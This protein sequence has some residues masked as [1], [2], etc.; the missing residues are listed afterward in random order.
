M[1]LEIQDVS[2]LL[3]LS[4]EEV[5][6][7]ALGGKLPAYRLGENRPYR[8]SKMEIEE[9]MMKN[10]VA[11]KF[12]DEKSG[13]EKTPGFSHFSLFRALTK[14]AV[15]T[16]LKASTKEGIIRETMERMAEK[17]ELDA[18]VLVDLLL[19][20]E[21]L[22]PTALGHGVGVPHARDFLLEKQHDLIILAL[23]KEPI[24]YGALDG[25]L[26]HSLFFLFAC[27]DKRHLH[28]LAKLAH[29]TSQ[30]ENIAFL[31]AR[32]ERTQLL[33]HVKAWESQF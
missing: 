21:S 14:G 6:K 28:L 9:W 8:F 2:E 18:D 1:D 17:L 19:D 23:P 27:Q 12:K 4:L 11:F 7:L 29:F 10:G 20:R 5:E 24:D 13:E 32:P 33:E 22:M 15:L 30:P 16:D 26:V 31:E 25:E 3:E